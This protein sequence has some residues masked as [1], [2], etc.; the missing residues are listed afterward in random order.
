MAE[1]P[2]V[3]RLL[4]TVRLDTGDTAVQ[5]GG[6]HPRAFLAVV[7]LDAGRVVAAERIGD[8]VWGTDHLPRGERAALQQTA[9]RVRRALR[10]AGL[11]DV[12]R[13]ELPGYVLD[14]AADDVD[15][16][17]FRA[18]VRSAREASRSG[19]HHRVAELLAD[20]L[21]LWEGPALHGLDLL[22]V[23]TV[24][25]ALDDE[26]W[27]AE[28]LRCGSL[29]ALGL[30]EQAIEHL[31]IATSAEPLR[32]PLWV[33]LTTAYLRSGYTDEAARCVRTATA[34]ITS[35]LGVAPGPELAKLEARL[36]A[37]TPPTVVSFGRHRL[38][39]TD[40]RRP[41]LDTALQR[42]IASAEQAARLA[43]AQGARQEAV[44]HW[45]RALE[46]SEVAAPE[47]RRRHLELLLELGETHND[48][49]LDE[50]ARRVFRRAAALARDLD[51]PCSLAR[52]ALGLCADRITFRPL[53]ESAAL[54]E[55]AL[56]AL[57][58][59]DQPALRSRLLSRL[60]IEVYWPGSIDR[61]SGLAA[62]A[63][64]EAER[65]GDN[66]SLLEGLN[67]A[68]FGAWTP[69]R[70]PELMAIATEYLTQARAAGNRAHE[71]L[72]HRWLALATTELG[73]VELGREHAAESLRLAD[74]LNHAPFQW[75]AR[76]VAAVHA[77]GAGDLD[78]A[79]RLASDALTIGSTVEPEVALDYVSL[80]IWTCRWLQGRLD[81]IADL[82]ETVARTPGVDLPR[83]LGL[84]M[85][86]AML[87][88]TAESAALL[89]EITTADLDTMP[90]D[91]SWFSG[92]T[93][94]AESLAIVPHAHA[95]WV[96]A[97]L[98]PLRTRI[99][100][101]PATVTGP[102][103]H[104]LGV[105]LWAAGRQDEALAA[106]AAAVASADR[107]GLPIFAARSRVAL[108]ERLVIAG[109]RAA[110]VRQ[111]EVALAPA[112]QLGLRRVA[113]DARRILDH[114]R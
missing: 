18:R 78:Q 73:D 37:E 66:D 60:A 14:V 32:E 106:L 69:S 46:L 92:V 1:P 108:A 15:A 20:A 107:A 25:A 27:Q 40:A 16:L 21:G 110:A 53:P 113:V 42:A 84:I 28:V 58:G 76:C 104:Q 52:A 94:L 109:D 9:T 39:A 62:Q 35:G 97:Q 34:V 33:L 93:A 80:L 83:R 63:R 72:A 111:A 43:T 90:R 22:P 4:G 2:P 12:L 51:D 99:G 85:T 7:A 71:H 96:V 30:S 77:I 44:R 112:E 87:G 8:L 81:E 82:V 67:A 19:D 45:Q 79:E 49:S 17:M 103:A 61:S 101:S 56:A 3:V 89:D 64:R 91:A 86:N 88:R 105:C 38:P 68:G 95:E 59:L 13:A 75:M 98:A 23:A 48:A 5:V 55:E 114:D 36:G 24:G 50:E 74:E 31:V 102:M 70:T 26:R 100:F 29:L 65:S 47:D 57:D 54:L 6:P 41:L 10:A 11:G